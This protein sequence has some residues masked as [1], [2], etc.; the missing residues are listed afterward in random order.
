[1]ALN[2]PMQA[3]DKMFRFTPSDSYWSLTEKSAHQN[4]DISFVH[5]ADLSNTIKFELLDCLAI[6]ATSH[7]AATFALS[8]NALKSF[9][10]VLQ[11]ENFS[12]YESAFNSLSRSNKE[13]LSGLIKNYHKHRK[14]FKNTALSEFYR[15]V[16]Y[17]FRPLKRD[18]KAILD[19]VKGALTKL[20]F[21]SYFEGLRQLHNKVRQMCKSIH[22]D[23]CAVNG[24]FYGGGRPQ[25]FGQRNVISGGVGMVL[26]TSVLRRPVQLEM[27]KTCD[28]R[29]A[30]G[31]YFGEKVTDYTVADYDELKL[32]TYRAKDGTDARTE[33]D[34]DI[35]LIN[36]DISETLIRYMTMNFKIFINS[37]SE[38]G[39]ELSKSKKKEL[40]TRFPLFPSVNLLKGL[41][42]NRLPLSEELLF[43]QLSK[44]TVWGHL[45]S[46]ISDMAHAEKHEVSPYF[47]SERFDNPQE[48]TVGNNR[49]R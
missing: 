35:H 28:F 8:K 45:A 36:A 38:H 31:D 12:D 10:F 34:K 14:Q 19:P 46:L 30:N 43:S 6:R 13:Q 4:I 40:F 37:M 18:N 21:E 2:E 39:V 3:K 9:L 5:N 25:R 47:K 27:I 48:M 49:F 1:K 11:G 26:L 16:I 41:D 29:M 22:G 33:L 42:L 23:D 15:K 32:K 24:S 44:Y 20:E 17:K 7:G